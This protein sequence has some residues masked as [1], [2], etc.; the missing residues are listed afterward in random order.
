MND[1][2]LGGKVAQVERRCGNREIDNAFNAGEKRQR[3]HR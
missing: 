1:A 3:H 2:R